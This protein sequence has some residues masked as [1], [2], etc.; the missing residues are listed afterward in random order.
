MPTQEIFRPEGATQARDV[1][2]LVSPLQGEVVFLLTPIDPRALPWAVLFGPFR[3]A[4]RT[5]VGQRGLCPGPRCAAPSGRRNGILSVGCVKR[6]DRIITYNP[7]TFHAPYDTRD[8]RASRSIR[9]RLMPQST[10]PRATPA[11]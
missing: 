9:A 10:K 2:K 5:C 1:Q 6:T 11:I 8:R 7:A 4:D 3:A